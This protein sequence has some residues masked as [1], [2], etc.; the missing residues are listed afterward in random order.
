MLLEAINRKKIPLCKDHHM[1]LHR[2]Y[3]FTEE[4]EKFIVVIMK[5]K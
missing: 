3:L 5:F 2:G 1:K 4:K